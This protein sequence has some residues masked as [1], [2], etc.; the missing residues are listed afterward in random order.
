M[1]AVR[2]SETSV[3]L[4]RT[5]RRFIPEDGT[6]QSH[7]GESLEPSAVM[8][9][10]VAFT[11]VHLGLPRGLVTCGSVVG[12]SGH[13]SWYSSGDVVHRIAPSPGRAERYVAA[14][15]DTEHQTLR[16]K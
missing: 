15:T 4:C 6:V 16:S 2:S 12:S 3:K 5:A 1:E 8:S 7:C 14:A 10:S 11:L 9:V 13:L